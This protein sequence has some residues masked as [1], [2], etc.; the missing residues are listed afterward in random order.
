MTG[1]GG[2]GYR[3]GRSRT[4]S[5]SELERQAEKVRMENK[6]EAEINEHLK[7]KLKDFNDRDTQNI[8]IHLET[9]RDALSKEIEIVNLLYGGSVS[10]YTYL[11]GLSDV[12]VLAIL[13][14]ESYNQ[15]QPHEVLD[16]F[17]D[18]LR[19][20]LPRTDITVGPL[21]VTIKFSDGHEIQVLPAIKTST[22]I[23]I[24]NQENNE[25][26]N[27]IKPH[28][29]AEKLTEV[30]KNNNGMVVR[31]IKIYKSINAQLPKNEQLSGYHIESLAIE[32]FENYDGNKN[33]KDML[34]YFV[35]KSRSHVESPISDSTGQSI[36]VDDYLGQSGSRDRE[37]RRDSLNR[38]FNAMNIMDSNNSIDQWKELLGE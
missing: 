1:S 34:K 16:I 4:S 30:N 14:D 23:R 27:V 36:H 32:V 2:G 6:Y 24:A 21:A 17:A 10:R 12:D 29:F 7:E 37:I 19:E 9:I 28:K 35:D 20:R 8:N 5:P 3:G 38:I 33:Y 13:N 18:R 25:W 26:S 15:Y 22:G 31:T 11:N